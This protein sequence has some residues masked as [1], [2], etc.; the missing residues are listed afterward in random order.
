MVNFRI[1]NADTLFTSCACA[2]VDLQHHLGAYFGPSY[3]NSRTVTNHSNGCL[4]SIKT[5]SFVHYS[6]WNFQLVFRH[7]GRSFSSFNL[8]KKQY[9]LNENGLRIK[10]KFSGMLALSQLSKKLY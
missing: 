3:N 6:S 5:D 8:N 9:V 7:P 4:V 2:F 10:G 1:H